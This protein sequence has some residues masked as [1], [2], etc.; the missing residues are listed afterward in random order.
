MVGKTVAIHG[1][2]IAIA[3]RT[4]SVGEAC[5]CYSAIL[6][7]DSEQIADLFIVLT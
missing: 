1:V 4:F 3:C 6:N 5:Y 7:E 2:S